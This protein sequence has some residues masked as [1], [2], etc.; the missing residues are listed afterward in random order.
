V[1][2][3]ASTEQTEPKSSVKP[4]PPKPS[5]LAGPLLALA[6]VTLFFSVLAFFGSA[7]CYVDLLAHFRVQYALAMLGAVAIAL[8]VRSWRVAAVAAIPLAI[9]AAVVLPL[10]IPAS[11]AAIDETIPPLKIVSF[12]V[13]TSN[14]Q[15]DTVAAYLLRESPEIILLVEIDDAWMR[16]MSTR[17]AGYRQ[18]EGQAQN[19]NFGLALFTRTDAAPLVVKA[20]ELRNLSGGA[21][22][23]PA[24][25]AQFHWHEQPLSL[26]GMHPVPPMSEPNAA[27]RD[28]E[29]ASA[30][31][32]SLDQQGRGQ[33]AIILGDLNATP[34]S[35][36]FRKLEHEGSLINSQRGFGIQPSF[37]ANWP[38]LL[39]IP[40]DHC[41]HDKKLRVLQ[42][43]VDP[44]GHGS[45][46][47]PLM[48]SVGWVE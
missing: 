20:T 7:N 44:S 15:F 22:A 1:I 46:H 17:L 11:T 10:Y 38:K 43:V 32:W 41:L 5:P 21:S 23:G 42:R 47:R 35:Y 36:A 6:L 12:N 14:R 37:K 4:F 28:A 40:I 34:W 24:I 48:V 8:A 39:G 16:E 45:D 18:I 31:R 25:F 27:A 3:V 30:A 29:L 13:H 9:N 26:L 19:N 33:A 2:A